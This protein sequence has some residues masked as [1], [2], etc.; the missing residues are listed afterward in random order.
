MLIYPAERCADLLVSFV[1]NRLTPTRLCFVHSK[2]GEEAVLVLAEARKGKGK[3]L[4]VEGSF[5][6]YGPDGKYTARAKTVWESEN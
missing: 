6:I 2:D 1:R 4:T 3:P 5:I